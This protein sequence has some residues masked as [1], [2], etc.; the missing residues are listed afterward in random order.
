MH[1]VYFFDESRFGTHSRIGHG[2]FETGARTAVKKKLGFKSFYVYTAAAPASGKEFSLLAPFVNGPCL[3][4]F[5]EKFSKWLGDKKAIVIMD[6]AGWHTRKDLKIP[7]NI[8]VIYLPPY[9]PEL[10]PVERLWQHMKDNVLKNKIYDTLTELENAICAF[11]N[12]IDVDIVRS[13]CSV[14]YMSC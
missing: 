3:E 8:E 10:N 14:S 6:Q 9:S 2:W 1:E 11:I 12:T 13:V 7:A 4:I 5:L